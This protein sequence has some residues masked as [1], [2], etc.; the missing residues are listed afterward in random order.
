MKVLT[1]GGAMIDTI[2]IIENSAIERMS[3]LN[4]GTSYLLLEDGRKTE[5]I[6]ISMHCGGGA[7]NTAISFARLGFDCATLI[8]IG[9]DRRGEQILASL[10][11]E[12]ISAQWVL[13]DGRAPTGS[14]VLVSSHDRNAGVF[15]FRGANTLLEPEDIDDRA[16]AVDLVYIANLSNEAARCFPLLVEKAR[17]AQARVAVNPGTRQLHAHSA[18]FKTALSEISILSLNRHEAED[19]LSL[20]DRDVPADDDALPFPGELRLPRL[21]T[22]GLNA[23]GRT[24][25]V[26]A[27]FRALTGEGV[28]SV[29][30]TDGKDG[31]F[32]ASNGRMIYCPAVEVE[33][34]GT[35]GAGDAFGSTFAAYIALGAAPDFALRA[36]ANNAAS[37]LGFIDTRS[38]LLARG[39]LDGRLAEARAPPH[40]IGWPL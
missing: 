30:L 23:N 21:A 12:R 37:V 36:A 34:A 18:A 32:A 31:A 14:S 11:E 2:A 26:R 3:L 24:I 29:V 15:T 6:D 22:R 5:A 13:R 1:V 4:A 16:F 19:V 40:V 25:S 10:A 17:A 38:G 9:D 33:V 27:F 8:K 20:L 7:V 39:E 28:G 35:A